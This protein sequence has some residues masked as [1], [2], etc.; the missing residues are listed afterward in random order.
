MKQTSRRSPLRVEKPYIPAKVGRQVKWHFGKTGKVYE[1]PA[2][3]ERVGW[4]T[5]GPLIQ[6]PL[7]GVM[8]RIRV[9]PA[10]CPELCPHP[11]PRIGA[12]G[13]RP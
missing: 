10:L 8:R 7:P 11:K 9:G 2:V 3:A 5:P 4:N 13:H 12:Q 6:A 1:C